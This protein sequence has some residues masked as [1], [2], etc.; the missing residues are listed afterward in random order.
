MTRVGSEGFEGA[1]AQ[2]NKRPRIFLFLEKVNTS[3]EGTERKVL[4]MGNR[5]TFSK[6]SNHRGLVNIWGKKNKAHSCICK[7]NRRGIRRSLHPSAGRN[8]DVRAERALTVKK[9]IPKKRNQIVIT[10]RDEKMGDKK[11][12]LRLQP[13]SGGRKRKISNSGVRSGKKRGGQKRGVVLSE[14]SSERRKFFFSLSGQG[15]KAGEDEKE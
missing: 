2:R 11:R 14:T 4:S 3:E 1:P 15:E 13:W 12:I 10:F 7:R 8:R 6:V 5:G 9:K